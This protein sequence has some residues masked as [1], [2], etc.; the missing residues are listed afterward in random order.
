[1]KDRDHVFY[2]AILKNNGVLCERVEITGNPAKRGDKD[3]LIWRGMFTLAARHPAPPNFGDT[4]HIR[5]DDKSQIA[6]VVTEVAGP[7]IHFRA[8]GRMPD[9]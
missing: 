6:L 1:M 7:T 3:G 8:R 2:G 9:V 4:L 5:L